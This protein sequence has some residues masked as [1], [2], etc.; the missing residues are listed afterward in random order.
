MVIVSQT[1][2]RLASVFLA[3]V[4]LSPVSSPAF[5]QT[6]TPNAA[7]PAVLLEGREVR[8]QLSPR[9]YTTL[10][11]EIP[12]K[13]LSIQ[14]QEGGA[15]EAGQTLVSFDCA[16]QQSQLDKAKATVAATGITLESNQEMIK[17]AAIGKVELQVSEAEAL[18]A[19]AEAKA[20]DIVVS[21]CKVLA[22]FNGRVAEQK[23]REEQFVQTGQ[24]LLEVIDDSLLE[25]EFIAPSSWLP[26]LRRKRSVRVR[27]DETGKSYIAKVARV[28]ARVDPVSQSIKVIAII[29]GRPSELMPGMSGRINLVQ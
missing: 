18:K 24:A 1:N 28:G 11:A 20:A 3:L 10:A 8:G 27:V 23:V 13:V 21:K 2:A 15:F 17:H 29:E 14:P 4:L 16:I 7:Q 12:A 26:S 22:P 9:R 5:A 19:Q 25:L 6:L